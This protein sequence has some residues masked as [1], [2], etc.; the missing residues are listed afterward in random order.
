MT[1]KKEADDWTFFLFASYV[2]KKTNIEKKGEEKLQ[3]A[4][5]WLITSWLISYFL[6][7]IIIFI[8]ELLDQFFNMDLKS[9]TSLVF[10]ESCSCDYCRWPA[11]IYDVNI[12]IWRHYIFHISPLGGGEGKGGGLWVRKQFTEN[13]L[14]NLHFCVDPLLNIVILQVVFSWFCW[15]LKIHSDCL[16]KVLGFTASCQTHCAS[17]NKKTP[18]SPEGGSYC[19]CVAAWRY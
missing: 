9:F 8:S 15:I 6:T 4:R 2:H 3:F 5:N 1:W 14:F 18:V 11:T 17:T 12:H 13:S 16:F 19:V 7:N 10:S